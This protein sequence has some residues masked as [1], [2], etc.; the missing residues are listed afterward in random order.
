MDIIDEEESLESKISETPI[1][2]REKKKSIK[3]KI[4][5]KDL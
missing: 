5:K 3:E 1:K 4:K 2:N